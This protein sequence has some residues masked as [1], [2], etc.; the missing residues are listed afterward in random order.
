M[1][2]MAAV[3]RM[4]CRYHASRTGVQTARQ[5]EVDGAQAETDGTLPRRSPRTV[6]ARIGA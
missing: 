3:L 1:L 6:P 4:W 5:P 2:R